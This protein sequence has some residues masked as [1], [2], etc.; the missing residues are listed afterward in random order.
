MTKQQKIEEL[1]RKKRAAEEDMALS[2]KLTEIVT[3]VIYREEIEYIKKR[4]I[5]RFNEFLKEFHAQRVK[6]LQDEM[7]FWNR[8]AD[9]EAKQPQ[10]EKLDDRL[11]TGNMRITTLPDLTQEEK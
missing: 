8:V 4:K 10:M 9:A 6:R 11:L 3:Q 5:Q 7:D 1:E 2:E